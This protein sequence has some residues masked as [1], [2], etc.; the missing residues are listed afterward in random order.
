[1]MY[2]GLVITSLLTVTVSM[3]EVL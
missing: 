1:M 2:V 3:M